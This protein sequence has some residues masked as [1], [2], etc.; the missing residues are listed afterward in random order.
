[1]SLTLYRRRMGTARAVP[2]QASDQTD[3]TVVLNRHDEP[4][5]CPHLALV[6]AVPVPRRHPDEPFDPSTQ[7]G[8]ASVRTDGRG[9]R[10]KREAESE[11]HA[12]TEPAVPASP[13]AGGLRRLP[14]SPRQSPRVV[15]PAHHIRS[16]VQPRPA[17]HPPPAD[18]AQ[19]GPDR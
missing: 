6:P 18:R 5:P 2:G 10:G 19:T 11:R 3:R 9:G 1:M 13:G 4:P 14:G 7:P 8:T 15:I 17:R 12:G 16:Y